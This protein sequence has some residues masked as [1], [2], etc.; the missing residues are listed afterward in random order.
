MHTQTDKSEILSLAKEL[1]SVPSSKENSQAL[2]QVLDVARKQLDGFT[3]EQFENNGIP[4]LLIYN[5][6]TRPEKFKVILNAHLD[7][8]PGRDEQ[9]SPQEKDGKLYGRGTYDMKAAAA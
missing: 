4:S 5:S 3:V 2:H 8:V 1:I 7:V 6:P 9:Y